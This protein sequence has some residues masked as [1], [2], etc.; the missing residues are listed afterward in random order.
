M[1]K[2]SIS[3]RA[4]LVRPCNLAQASSDSFNRVNI[5]FLF[6]CLNCFVIKGNF[7]MSICINHH[8]HNL[9]NISTLDKCCF[10]VVDQ[11]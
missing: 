4:Q 8:N 3:A 2:D 11:R 10:N 1:R 7:F 9:A 5:K 6:D